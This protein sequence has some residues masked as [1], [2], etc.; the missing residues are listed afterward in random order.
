MHI[1]KI[2][3]ITYKNS[4]AEGKNGNKQVACSQFSVSYFKSKTSSIL[5]KKEKK[6][7]LCPLNLRGCTITSQAL[8]WS[9]IRCLITQQNTNHPIYNPDGTIM[10]KCFENYMIKGQDNTLKESIWA[11]AQADNKK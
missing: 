9:V 6:K 11:L 4:S 10:Q 3:C 2:K 1:Q 8:N 7:K 5:V